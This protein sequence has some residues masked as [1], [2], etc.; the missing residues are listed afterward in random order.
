MNRFAATRLTALG[1]ALLCPAASAQV[2]LKEVSGTVEQ[3]RG[4]W[5]LARNGDSVAQALRTG[6]G[7]VSFQ[8]GN[9]AQVLMGSSSSLEMYQNEPSFQQGRFYVQGDGRFY[10]NGI[11]YFTSGRVRVD[12]QGNVQRIGVI[13][14]SLRIAV[15]TDVSTIRTGQQYDLKT[16]KTSPFAEN[17]PWYLSKF[18]GVGD[19]QIEAVNGTV[20]LQLQNGSSHAVQPIES[21]QPGQVL[22]TGDKSWAE[23]SFTGGGYLRLQP[24]S[25]L[26]VISVEKTARGREVQLKLLRGSAW[27]VV[28]KGQGGYQITTPTVTTAVR[29]TIFR[30][31]SGGTVKVF[32]GAVALPTNSDITLPVGQQIDP[33]GQVQPLSPDQGD[34][35]NQALDAAHNQP[36]SLEISLDEVQTHFKMLVRSQPSSQI[37]VRLTPQGGTPLPDFKLSD[38][39]PSQPTGL[40]NAQKDLPEGRYRVEVL[41]QRFGQKRHFVGSVL[42]D[43]QAPQLSQV[44]VSRKGRIALLTGQVSDISSVLLK[45]TLGQQTYTQ[46]VSA[47][48]K[49]VLWTL[50][51]AQSNLPI[52]LSATDQAGN[53]TTLSLP[54]TSLPPTSPVPTPSSD[55][56]TTHAS[57]H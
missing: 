5:Q 10:V 48:G 30:V 14:G 1:L 32:D 57:S 31:D 50:P 23:V 55:K 8:N 38:T 34:L 18:V 39:T 28:A 19:A 24:Q 46:W 49:P 44:T 37:T 52:V 27:N 4:T 25:A 42:L 16:L 36:L 54:E 43:R 33:S 12:L 17:D 7:R 22:T 2:L 29:G 40:F 41:A 11:H 56:A 51:L 6:T 20:T 3:Q 21:L 45:A 9:G 26:S 35:D 15:N 47:A 13:A 53:T